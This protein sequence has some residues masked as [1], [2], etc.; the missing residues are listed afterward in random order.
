MNPYAC[1]PP[2][3]TTETVPKIRWTALCSS[4]GGI[5]MRNTMDTKQ[6]QRKLPSPEQTSQKETP[7]YP[8]SESSITDV[9]PWL[10]E[11][12]LATQQQS[13]KT[14]FHCSQRTQGQE[15]SPISSPRDVRVVVPAPTATTS[16]DRL[17]TT[18]S[19]GTE[20]PDDPITKIPTCRRATSRGRFHA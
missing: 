3:R 19:S 5:Q 7:A 9:K 11:V 18:Y 10:E 17:C 14:R 20:K 15:E 13:T 2:K 12:L 8:E 16:R 1:K 6:Y 4:R